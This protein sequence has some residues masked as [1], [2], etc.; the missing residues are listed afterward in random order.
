MAFP[1]A[2]AKVG[3]EVVS[4]GWKDADVSGADPAKPDQVPFPQL[5]ARTVR[6]TLG[7][8]RSF[9]VAPD[10]GRVVFLRS[11]SGTDRAHGLWLF[12]VATGEERCVADPAVLL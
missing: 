11:K 3:S 6:F 2:R 10:G 9:S 8:P 4:D 1:K 7:E 5:Y 12:D